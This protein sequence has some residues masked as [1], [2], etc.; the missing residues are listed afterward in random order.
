MVI[1]ICSGSSVTTVRA[2]VTKCR[3]ADLQS[4]FKVSLQTGLSSKLH[5]KM[6]VGTLTLVSQATRTAV[7]MDCG[8]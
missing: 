3:S 6:L 7:W 5:L 1:S 2:V 8:L 4:D